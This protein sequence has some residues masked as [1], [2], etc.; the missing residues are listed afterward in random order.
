MRINN[1]NLLNWI[2][3]GAHLGPVVYIELFLSLFAHFCTMEYIR[4]YVLDTKEQSVGVNNYTLSTWK[5]LSGA[6]ERYSIEWKGHKIKPKLA[7]GDY[8]AP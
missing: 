8:W 4:T 5:C 6:G 3:G 7:N 2:E 1:K